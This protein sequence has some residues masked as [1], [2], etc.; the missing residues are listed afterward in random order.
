MDL[1]EFLDNLDPA[2]QYFTVIQI[3]RGIHHHGLNLNIP[4]N[5]NIVFFTC[6][7][8]NK[9]KMVRNVVLPLIKGNIGKRN[10][11]KK[12]PVSFVGNLDTHAIRH[13]L[14]QR[15]S[16]IVHFAQT[17]N[18][19]DIM[20]QSYFSF[21]PRGFGPTSFRLFEAIRLGS[22]PIYFWED[23]LLL[24]F[25]ELISWE[26]FSIVL[27][28]TDVNLVID[29]MMKA[30]YEQMQESLNKVQPFFTMEYTCS[31]IFD[32]LLGDF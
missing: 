14:Y 32:K 18:W 12:Y 29:L 2:K 3:A 31:Y 23:D 13:E 30:D 26:K 27:S 9:G 17:D 19:K 22:V 10:L 1:Q 20:E 25:Q 4:D 7:G 8:F 24:P 21:A 16:N 15:Y 6:G 28:V 5:I 11:S